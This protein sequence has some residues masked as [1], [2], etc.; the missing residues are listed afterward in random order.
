MP[1]LRLILMPTSTKTTPDQC[2]LLVRHSNSNQVVL[3]AESRTRR[4]ILLQDTCRLLGLEPVL[5]R[6]GVRE[7]PRGLERVSSTIRWPISTKTKSSSTCLSPQRSVALCLANYL[8]SQRKHRKRTS[9]SQ[10]LMRHLL[11]RP[12]GRR[13]RIAKFVLVSS[14][15]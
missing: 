10:S 15:K 13:G 2:R 11:R 4:R 14:Q 12:S 5:R 1:W 6:E 3:V 9:T 7:T 8:R